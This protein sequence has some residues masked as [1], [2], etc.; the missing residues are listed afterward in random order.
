M[1]LPADAWQ[2]GDSADR[3]RPIIVTRRKNAASTRT[4][5][6]AVDQALQRSSRMLAA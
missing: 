6:G 1:P 3:T 2:D 4:A 5:V